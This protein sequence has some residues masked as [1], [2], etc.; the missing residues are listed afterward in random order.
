MQRETPSYPSRVLYRGTVYWYMQVLI[1]A[2][3]GEWR[4]LR[5]ALPTRAVYKENCLP[6]C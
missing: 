2:H 6:A 1:P 4:N 5:R 3:A